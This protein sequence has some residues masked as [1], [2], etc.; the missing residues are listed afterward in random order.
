MSH[1]RYRSK[2]ERTYLQNLYENG[3]RKSRYLTDE[4]AV[5]LVSRIGI[6]KFKGYVYAFQPHIQRYSFD[7][8]ITVFF[9]DKYLSRLLMDMTSGIE[10]RLKATLIEV[11]YKHISNLP[12]E[13]P[14]KDNPFF[15]LIQQNYKNTNPNLHGPSID[16]WHIQRTSFVN[17]EQYTHYGL[18][19]H[20][21]YDFSSNK[22]M[23]LVNAQT[24]PLKSD[25][26]YPPFHYFVE[27][28]TLGTI[29]YLIKH[30][31]IGSID[32]MEQVA[33]KFGILNPKKV[34]FLPY[35]ERLNEVRNRAAHR[36]RLFNR[37]YR[38]VSRV[39]HYKVLSRTIKEHGFLDVYIFLFFMLGK[40]DSSRYPNLNFFA[41]EEVERLFRAFKKDYYI[42]QDSLYVT[43]KLKRKDFEKIKKF[44]WRGMT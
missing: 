7:D 9:F 1:Y 42:R 27:G 11:C 5:M 13:H 28:A 19:Y 40:L 24:I 15:Y 16:N 36:E 33:K 44:I 43:K 10:T 21:K 41:K 37:S 17:T 38:S 18:Y 12:K 35:L 3:L 6:F 30:L 32:I 31:K 29:K 20:T 34:D 14:Q 22:S 4:E 26:N 25:I 2:N 39:G 23:Y 8:A